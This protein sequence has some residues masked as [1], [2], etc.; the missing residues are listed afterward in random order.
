M[1]PIWLNL[2]L[3]VPLY[4][5]ILSLG[6]LTLNL[7]IRF[8]H[9]VLTALLV[10]VVN[11]GLEEW[12]GQ[13]LI[14][15][16]VPVFVMIGL[17]AYLSETNLHKS[18]I[19]VIMGYTIYAFI[20]S[21]THLISYNIFKL[22]PEEILYSSSINIIAI[23]FM[24]SLGF[25]IFVLIKTFNWKLYNLAYMANDSRENEPVLTG[26]L[27]FIGISFVVYC[28][29]L[30]LTFY[31]SRFPEL[32]LAVILS[33]GHATFLLYFFYTCF[34]VKRMEC[35][36]EKSYKY[37]ANRGVTELLRRFF[38]TRFNAKEAYVKQ[39]APISLIPIP[40]LHLFFQIQYALAQEKQVD[41]IL[42]TSDLSGL[43]AYVDDDFIWMLER[44]YENA[45]EAIETAEF[46][47]IY[48]EI[49][50]DDDGGFTV[51]IKNNGDVLPKGSQA[52]P[53]EPG[54]TTRNSPRRGYGLH[55]VKKLIDSYQGSIDLRGTDGYTQAT[56][57][58]PFKESYKPEQPKRP[59]LRVVKGG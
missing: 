42:Q 33:I 41:F 26:V 51:I 35:A 54:Y 56:I 17:V 21:I 29:I 19:M 47:E 37:N 18:A 31:I 59:V 14:K 34:M 53:F 55:T 20:E 45:F 1:L 10:S 12:L 2:L 28:L 4:L 49:A 6:S 44:L 8:W 46:K 27:A 38:E 22:L 3:T 58:L 11:V 48:S 7:K 39:M 52:H 36:S 24:V 43:E 30:G 13:S 23:M 9:W 15:I 40:Q 57:K 32:N 50:K 25:C 16:I 5:L